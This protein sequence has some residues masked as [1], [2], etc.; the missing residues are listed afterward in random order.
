MVALIV[1]RNQNDINSFTVENFRKWPRL[2]R[3]FRDEPGRCQ[4]IIKSLNTKAN[5]FFQWVFLM[6][7]ELSR[8]HHSAKMLLAL[9]RS[10]R[11]VLG[12]IENVAERFSESL[13][14]SIFSI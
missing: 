4:Q 1:R 9:D 7:C 5:G 12:L 10:P 11:S 3:L 14:K 8:M 13:P 6:I 2:K